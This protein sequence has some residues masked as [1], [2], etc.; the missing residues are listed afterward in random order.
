[1]QGEL[2]ERVMHGVLAGAIITQEAQ[3]NTVPKADFWPAGLLTTYRSV[4]CGATSK[5]FCAKRT[6]ERREGTVFLCTRLCLCRVSQTLS[7]PFLASVL[8]FSKCGRPTSLSAAAGGNCAI[9]GFLTICKQ[10]LTETSLDG[11]LLNACVAMLGRGAC[12]TAPL[13]K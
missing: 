4:K 1:M 2:T 7:I 12:V 3:S 10:G 9:Q 5:R 8:T 13:T 11:L 6:Q